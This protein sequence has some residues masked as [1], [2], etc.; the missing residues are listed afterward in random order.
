MQLLQELDGAGRNNDGMVFIAATNNPWNID[1]ALMSRFSE[2]CYVPLPDAAARRAIFALRFQ[3]MPVS[4]SLDIDELV[5]KTDGLGGREIV[6]VCERANKI[7]FRK[8]TQTG[9]DEA[10]NAD[11]FAEALKNVKP[12]VSEKSLLRYNQWEER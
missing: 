12:K 8:L 10:V 11:D 9:I 7:S 4:D 2:T 6:A 1:E 5:E 3:K